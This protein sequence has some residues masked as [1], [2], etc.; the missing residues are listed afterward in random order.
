[1]L[2]LLD[3]LLTSISSLLCSLYMFHLTPLIEALVLNTAAFHDSTLSSLATTCR[4][5]GR[6]SL[7]QKE[8]IVPLKAV[9]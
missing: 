7:G 1:M 8:V 6:G 4:E 9:L 3:K 2:Q 5:R